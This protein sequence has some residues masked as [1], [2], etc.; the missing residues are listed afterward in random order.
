MGPILLFVKGVASALLNP[1][2]WVLLA[3]AAAAAALPAYWHGKGVVQAD[4]EIERAEMARLLAEERARKNEVL[5]QVVTKY[6]DRVKIVKE[7]GDDVIVKVPVYISSDERVSTG[8]VCIHDWAAAG[9][10]SAPCVAPE[11]AG[12]SRADRAGEV[13]A[14]NYQ[15]YHLLA[16]QVKALQDYVENVCRAPSQ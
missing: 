2:V 9:D 12:G 13:I 6:V 5:V 3:L 7:K 14:R 4:W 1:F 8:F 11:G 15:R 10:S 16:E